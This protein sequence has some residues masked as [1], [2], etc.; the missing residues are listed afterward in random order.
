M[1][2]TL[3]SN[4]TRPKKKHYIEKNGMPKA[5]KK[6]A[7]LFCFLMCI[8]AIYDI[9]R[10]FFTNTYSLLLAFNDG[11]PFTET[12]H[13][14]F[15][16]FVRFFQDIQGDGE[17]LIALINT[18][19]YFAVGIISLFLCYFVAYFLYKKIPGHKAIRYLLFLPSLIP[20]I[21][22]TTIYRG[23]IGKGGPFWTLWKN[24]TGIEY[25]NPWSNGKA[26]TVAI[27]IYMFLGGFGTTYLIFIGAMN[28]IPKEIIDS[29]KIDGCSN[30]REFW[31]IIVPMTWSTFST[32]LLMDVAL[33]FTAS[34]PILYFTGEKSI[35]LG[36]QTIGYWLFQQVYD[37]YYNYPS[38]VGIVFTLLGLPLV[39]G[40]R[41]LI[42]KID[43]GVT[44]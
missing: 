40:T 36:T 4:R 44:Y 23:L 5:M 14:S 19:R 15:S 13:W 18:L 43:S 41:I 2:K 17:I 31:S 38:A 25:V 21:I 37:N 35:S 16:Q 10:Y 9:V 3:S 28:R 22:S 33:I 29:A 42:D 1:E 32:F 34:G 11:T 7:Y 20:P 27:I 6:G 8:P 12:S 39:I 26:A 24:M 30:W